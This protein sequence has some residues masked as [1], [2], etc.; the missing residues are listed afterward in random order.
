MVMIWIMLGGWLIGLIGCGGSS[1]KESDATPGAGMPDQAA[2]PTS[3]QAVAPEPGI[4]LTG[5]I[6][7]G[8][9]ANKA[10]ITINVSSDGKSLAGWGVYFE[11][12]E[13]ET[14]KT[15]TLVMQDQSPQT[16]VQ[17]AFED[18]ISNIGEL[19][20]QFTSS[21]TASGTVHL[22][23]D[24]G[25]GGE[26]ECGT[27]DWSVEKSGMAEVITPPPIPEEPTEIGMPTIEVP[28]GIPT[29][30]PEMGAVP[31][32]KLQVV[33]DALVESE[34]RV[35]VNGEVKN[36]SET[37]IQFIRVNARLLD[38]SGN[39]VVESFSYGVPGICPPGELAAFSVMIDKPATYL[40]YELD[41]EA[42][43]TS[44]P[45]FTDLRVVGEFTKTDDMGMHHIFGIVENT[46]S[47]T[48]EHSSLFGVLYDENGKVVSVT[49]SPLASPNWLLTPGER[50]TFDLIPYPFET[51]YKTYRLILEGI[52][53][54]KPPPPSLKLDQIEMIGDRMVGKA[55]FPGPGSAT[56][57]AITAVFFDSDGNII[58]YSVGIT[59]PQV[60]ATGE[61]ATFEMYMIPPDFDHYEV[62]TSYSI[63]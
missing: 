10:L 59:Y 40:G 41:V 20:G 29:L 22:N 32:D 34:D 18:K 11:D 47:T 52:P 36:L 17:S 13:C 43:T 56:I 37:N 60:V 4:Q 12:L 51:Q 46:G 45:P 3:M 55:I 39:Q 63:D 50:A 53:S 23:F 16:I 27:W 24:L 1:G 25:F 49:I 19:T 35:Y 15:G 54:A 8:D 7:L 61:S 28:E 48:L 33:N 42:K 21:V 2:P 44:A 26:I 30:V 9:R 62:Y 14:F 58:D 31:P 5:S 57:Y 38:T 6:E